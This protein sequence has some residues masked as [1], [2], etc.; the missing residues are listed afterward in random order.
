M[1]ARI[2][3]KRNFLFFLN[4][5]Y[6]V[7]VDDCLTGALVSPSSWEAVAQ[8][9]ESSRQ[10]DV[11]ARSIDKVHLYVHVPF[12]ERLCSFC[13]CSRV[14]LRQR[15]DIDAYIK[16][17]ARQ[18]TILSPAYQGMD[19]G[20]IQ[21]G[22]GTPSI[23]DERQLSAILDG[24]DKS[25]PSRNRQIQ[26]EANPSSWSASKLA[27]LSSR[28]LYRLSIGV[29]TLD[30]K[31]LKYVSRPQTR[32]K[33]LGCLRLAQKAGIPQVNVDLMAGLPGQ[34][35]EGFIHDLKDVISEGMDFINIQ[36][37][38]SLS[39]QL[40][41]GPGETIPAFFNRRDAMMKMAKEVLAQAGFTRKGFWGIYSRQ[42]EVDDPQEEV[43][44]HLQ[45]ALA[46]FGPFARGLFPGAVFYRAGT[47]RPGAVNTQVESC[48]QDL[49]YTMS[50]YAVLAL[51]N[52]L[53]E[54]AF[55]KRFRVSIDRH[56]GE[57]LRYLQE[58]GLVA[59]SKGIWKFS[60]KWEIRRIREYFALSR[61]LFGKGLLSRL[62][63]RFVNGYD[64]RHDYSS[65]N[66]LLKAYADSTLM[67]VYYRMG[68]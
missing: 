51:I 7:H 60:G 20:L 1:S 30:E 8:R 2:D 52:G 6:P 22:G 45:A 66:S 31:I 12:C 3:Q 21:F 32:K 42:E 25:F 67:V 15:S 37:Y 17:L 44:T 40:L 34:T 47:V 48:A 27:L 53:D 38:T 63:E 5:I 55:L 16:D 54:Q 56:C 57:G 33:V 28:G 24:V 11:F 23:L 62:R 50:H 4:E 13:H 36:P 59:F 18:M 26:F 61:A 19:A 64:P 35:V 65:G 46:A 10:K 43:Y 29:Q 41:C 9:V 68:C 49:D 39:W 58:S 14:L